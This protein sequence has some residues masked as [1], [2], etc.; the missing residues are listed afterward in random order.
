MNIYHIHDKLYDLTDFISKHP[1]GTDMFTIMLRKTSEE[2]LDI[3]PLVYSYH[4]NPNILFE[5]LP[6]YEIPA[7][8]AIVKYKS[9]YVY[10]KYLELK[11][12]VYYEIH[13]KKLPLYWSNKE[14]AY[15]LVGFALYVRIWMHCFQYASIISSW[16]FVLLSIFNIW[17]CALI[18]HETSHYSGFKNQQINT[19]VSNIA[20]A[21]IF[22]NEEWKWDHN[23]LHHSFTNTELDNDY[24]GHLQTFRHSI[25]QPHFLQHRIQ[26]IYAYALFWLGG[27]SG[28][29]DSVKHKR[30]NFAL[31]LIILYWFGMTNTFIFYGLTGFMFLSIAQLSHIQPECTFGQSKDFLQNQVSNTI[32]YKTENPAIRLMCFGLDIQIE[33]HLFPN[34]PHS[35]LRQVQHI[36][37]EYCAK[38]GIAYIEKQ[39]IFVMIASYFRHLCEMGK[40]PDVN[41]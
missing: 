24:N 25:E 27:F 1:G 37:R 34:I 5:I 29:I 41:I 28:Q 9:N 31:F 18:F 17:H 16:W 39:D 8:N 32:N 15:N 23:Y 11:K 30:W 36:V 20:V 4:T 12:L 26:H 3:T 21:P 2:I 22:T 10:D 7:N 6:K 40:R 13:D 19:I 35:T 33:H 38:N 14:I